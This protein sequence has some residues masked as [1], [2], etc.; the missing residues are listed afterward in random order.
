MVL[1]EE[2]QTKG[3]VFKTGVGK[4]AGSQQV[5]QER[6]YSAVFGTIHAANWAICIAIS[7]AF[8]Y[9]E[10]CRGRST[11]RG[12]GISCRHS[13]AYGAWLLRDI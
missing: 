13:F 12:R 7:I 10:P 3:H 6:R 4:N 9:T 11:S 8:L 2:A 1:T 5:T